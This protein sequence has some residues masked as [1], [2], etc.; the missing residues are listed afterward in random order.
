MRC[1]NGIST[2]IKETLERSLAPSSVGGH[3]A[4][5]VIF[6]PGSGPVPT[7]DFTVGLEPP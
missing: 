1:T 2:L 5:M 7:G 4:K 6:E 3:R